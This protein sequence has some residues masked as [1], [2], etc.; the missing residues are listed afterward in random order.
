[1]TTENDAREILFAEDPVNRVLVAGTFNE[2]NHGE[3]I[4]VFNALVDNEGDQSIGA[5]HL[6][7]V[8]GP[9]SSASDI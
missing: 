8:G 9:S 6:S 5:T 7:I 4:N 3:T 2:H 1:M